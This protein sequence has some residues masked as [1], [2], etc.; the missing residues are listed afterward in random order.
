MIGI[1]DFD[2]GEISIDASIYDSVIAAF[3]IT[4]DM[5]LRLRWKDNPAFVVAVGG[6]H[7]GFTPPAD[8]PSL[9]R[10]AISLATGDNPRLRLEAYFALTSNTVQFGAGFELATSKRRGSKWPAR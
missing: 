2:R 9:N 3:A 7:P 8:F 5:A 4:G 10:L 6:F 1:I